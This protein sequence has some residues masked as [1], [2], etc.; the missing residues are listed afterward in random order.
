[1]LKLLFNWKEGGGGGGVFDEIRKGVYISCYKLFSFICV[2]KV[3]IDDFVS[4]R[5]INF[6]L[7]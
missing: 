2:K 3:G 7:Y 5:K 4:V 6:F 1:M